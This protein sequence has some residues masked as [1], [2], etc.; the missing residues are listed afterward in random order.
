LLK[1]KQLFVA[2]KSW[3]AQVTHP[4]MTP[5]AV[6]VITGAAAGIGLAAATKFARMGP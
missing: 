1:P 5:G 4:A 6:A 3:E 2:L